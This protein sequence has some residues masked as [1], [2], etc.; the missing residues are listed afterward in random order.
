MGDDHERIWLEPLSKATIAAKTTVYTSKRHGT[1]EYIRADLA[2]AELAAARAE[3]ER[4]RAAMRNINELAA[5]TPTPEDAEANLDHI[6]RA[7]EA[8][9]LQIPEA[10]R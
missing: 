2:A 8:A 4:L 7:S 3:I 6:Y 5:D 9:L 10:P 1:T